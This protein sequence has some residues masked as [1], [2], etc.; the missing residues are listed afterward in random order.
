MRT[1]TLLLTVALVAAGAASSM[2]Q[3]YSQNAVGYINVTI[4][5]GFNLIA[6]QLVSPNTTVAS[7]LPGVPDQTTVYKFASGPGGGFTIVTYDLSG[8]GGW[9]DPNLTI[10]HGG[11]VFVQN[12]TANNVTVTFVGDVLQGSPI[13]NPIPANFSI[14]S[15][16]VPQAGLIQ[17]DLKF[18]PA[19]QDTVYKFVNPTGYSIYTYDLS[20]VG[21]WDEQPTFGVGE[22]FF[23]LSVAGH[24]WN[25]NFSVN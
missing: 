3:V 18:T 23:V 7:L 17:T 11:G 6:N 22:A 16:R 21:D 12:P 4:K 15:S 8:I 2:A 13:S 9:D 25:R 20:G 14:R 24:S 5:P 10:D 19:D 1:K